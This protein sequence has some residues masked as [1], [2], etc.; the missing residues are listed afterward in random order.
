MCIFLFWLWSQG[1]TVTLLIDL[2]WLSKILLVQNP[3]TTNYHVH[4]TLLF[5]SLFA[6]SAITKLVADPR[7]G[8]WSASL[9]LRRRHK[10]ESRSYANQHFRGQQISVS[11]L[12]I[13]AQI[14][15]L[16]NWSSKKPLQKS[17]NQGLPI[18]LFKEVKHKLFC[19]KFIP[20]VVYHSY[21]KIIIRQTFQFGA[22]D[23]NF[24]NKLQTRQ[25]QGFPNGCFQRSWAKKFVLKIYTLC[26]SS[27]LQWLWH[28]WNILLWGIRPYP[29]K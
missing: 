19:S 10:D 14:Y 6:P 22:L 4:R 1:N 25:N 18:G 21:S 12:Q 27:F 20:G 3:R 28:P 7:Y 24:E 16:S 17:S 11:S 26:C 8:T 15:R 29:Q 9:L 13:S 5:L 23:P 2:V